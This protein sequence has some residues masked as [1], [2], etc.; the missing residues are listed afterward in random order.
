[1]KMKMKTLM[2]IYVSVSMMITAGCKK[3][4]PEEIKKDV[5]FS[6][7]SALSADKLNTGGDEEN[8][9]P[10]RQVIINYYYSIM[11]GGP[12][13]QLVDGVR[14]RFNTGY[15]LGTSDDILK[16]GANYLSFEQN[17]QFFFVQ[18]RP[19][20]NWGV[21]DTLPMHWEYLNLP[22]VNPHNIQYELEVRTQGWD[23]TCQSYLGVLIDSYQHS[24]TGGG[25]LSIPLYKNTTTSHYFTAI[26][27]NEF[28]V[29]R[30]KLR[31]SNDLMCWPNPM[32]SGK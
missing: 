5:A 15:L 25:G 16:F 19:L 24:T 17:S 32:K 2:I 3:Q 27:G 10:D 29:N 26:N 20:F 7:T 30:F 22:G 28:N 31:I 11:P 8:L 23:S 18:K 9:G 21:S 12:Y 14:S 13:H 6:Q 4:F 1:M